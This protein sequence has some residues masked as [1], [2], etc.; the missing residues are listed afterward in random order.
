MDVWKA[1]PEIYEIMFDLID[2]HHH[3]L[4]LVKDEIGIALKEK[5]SSP[6]GV[7]VYGKTSKAAPLFNAFQATE[8]K[9]L[10]VLAGDEWQHT[11]SQTQKMALIDHHLC[12]MLV[13]EDADEGTVKCSVKPPDFIGYRAEV[14]RWGFWR[15]ECDP[16]APTPVEQMFG[17]IE[18][19]EPDEAE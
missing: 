14:E 2:K 17:V 15:P 7:K 18:P 8:Y 4:L 6:G 11:L 9:F 19:D 10:I 5:A 3:H 13:E 16:D 1:G 12:S